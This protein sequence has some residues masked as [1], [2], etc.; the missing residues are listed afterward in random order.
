MFKVGDRVL[1]KERYGSFP[2]GTEATVIKV[3]SSYWSNAQQLVITD[4]QGMHCYDFRL[5]LVPKGFNVSTMT[6]QELADEF[7]RTINQ[8]YDMAEALTARGY[9]IRLPSNGLVCGY[10]ERERLINKTVTETVVL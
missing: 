9:K 7:R 1:L 2:K 4:V 6:D 3:V 10:K 8:H 5:E